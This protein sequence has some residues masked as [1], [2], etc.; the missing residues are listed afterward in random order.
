MG[1]TDA[2][3][4][5]YP[6]GDT[7]LRRLCLEARN[8]GLDS[9]VCIDAVERGQIHDVLV[10]RGVIIETGS[11]QEVVARVKKEQRTADLILVRA[12]DGAFNRAA[13]S[14]RGVHILRGL[15]SAPKRAFDQVSAKNAADKGIAID[16]DFFPLIHQRGASRQKALRCYRDVLRLHRKFSF[17]LTISSGARSLLDLRS[18]REITRLCAVFGMEPHEVEDALFTVDALLEPAG[19][20]EVI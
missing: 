3:V 15:G 2:C 19:P 9:I 13:L 14:Y 11:M 10:R 16:I 17:P 12:G 4:F 18:V 1:C 8:L 5:P 6:H 7:S 20:V